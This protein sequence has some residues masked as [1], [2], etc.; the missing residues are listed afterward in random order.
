MLHVCSTQELVQYYQ[1]SSL[2]RSFPE[3]PIVLGL[4]YKEA[5]NPSPQGLYGSWACMNVL[6]GL[7]T[8]LKPLA[9]CEAQCIYI[10]V[11]MWIC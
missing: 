1:T 6:I 7:V 4:P 11:Y 5:I 2:E 8:D 9:C 3:V 10:Y